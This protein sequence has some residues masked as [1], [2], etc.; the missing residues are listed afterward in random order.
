MAN[1]QAPA[2]GGGALLPAEDALDLGAEFRREV[3][4]VEAIRHVGREEADLG[5]AIIAA[6]LEL[7][8]I[9]RLRRGKREPGVGQLALAAGAGRLLLQDAEDLRLQN[10]APGDREV[11]GRLGRLR[12]LDHLR[13]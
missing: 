10:V 8:P 4:A 13:N 1:P 3:G 12:L 7:Q 11:R 2:A 5:A 9:E 6:A